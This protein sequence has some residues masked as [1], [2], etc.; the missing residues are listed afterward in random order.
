MKTCPDCRLTADVAQRRGGSWPSFDEDFTMDFTMDFII[1][2]MRIL[3][4][5]KNDMNEKKH[6]LQTLFYYADNY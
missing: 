1:R 6:V 5:M 3:G 2:N 4:P